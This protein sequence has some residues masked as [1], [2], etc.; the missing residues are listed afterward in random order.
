MAVPV[1]EQRKLFQRSGDRCAFPRCGKALTAQQTD[2]EP[3][4]A[5]GEIAHIVG[6]SPNGPRGTSPLRS[7]QRNRYENLILLCNY[8]HQLIDSHP[9]SWS[10]AQLE[11][12]KRTH[13]EWVRHRLG[14]IDPVTGSA[15]QSTQGG[16]DFIEWFITEADRWPIVD[17][18]ADRALLGIH[19]ALP[20]PSNPHESLSVQLPEYVQRD[21]DTELR[22]AVGGA[23]RRSGFIV[24]VGPSASGKTRSAYE[25]VHAQ[26]ADWRMIIPPTA[27]DLDALLR[28]GTP[29]D[30]SVIWLDEL[31][32]YLD[33]GALSLRTFHKILAEH[34]GPLLVIGT[35]WP[36][37]FDRICEPPIKD[38]SRDSSA[39]A[40]SIL[41]LATRFDI[42][43]AFTESEYQRATKISERD[44]R[45]RQALEHATDAAIPSGLACAPELIHRW[46]QPSDPVGAAVI[47]AAV[48]ARLC[49]HPSVI[50]PGLLQLLAAEYLT[51]AQRATATADW[52][53]KALQ[54]AMRPIRG[55]V[56]ALTPAARRIGELDGYQPSDILTHR[57]AQSYAM[58]RQ[59][60][61]KP[62][63]VLVAHADK[64]ASQVIAVFASYCGY[65]DTA[66]AAWVRLAEAGDTSAMVALGLARLDD[67]DDE[68]AAP[69]FRRAADAG[70]TEAMGLL[71]VALEQLGR[72]DEARAWIRRGAEAGVPVA[73]V[74]LGRI[75]EDDGDYE[76]ARHWYEA[77]TAAG[78]DGTGRL[79]L[80]CMLRDQGD[81]ETACEY[82]HEAAEAGR[83]FAGPDLH[84]TAMP[85]GVTDTALG[86]YRESVTNTYASAAFCLGEIYRSQERFDEAKTWFHRAANLGRVDG[87]TALG[88]LVWNEGE[89]E[90]ALTWLRPA[91]EAGEPEAMFYVAMALDE[92]EET[93]EAGTWFRK[94][95]LAGHPMAM[96]RYAI[97]LRE[98]GEDGQALEW[99]A[100]AR[101]A[102]DPLVDLCFA[103]ANEESS[104]PPLRV[105]P[106]DPGDLS[107]AISWT[108]MAHTCE[109]VTDWGWDSEHADPLRFIAWCSGVV[110]EEC[111]WHAAGRS[112]EGRTPLLVQILPHG[113]AFYA[114]PATGTDVELGRRI[115]SGV[116]ELLAMAEHEDE[117]G[118]LATISPEYRAWLES[119][120]YDVAE[121]WFK[122]R[123]MDLVLNR[124]A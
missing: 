97:Y 93:G 76:G 114:R 8:H 53:D 54:W 17:S 91:A 122:T 25:A 99:L 38:H 60:P 47:T 37:N 111:P 19:P 41:R 98:Q 29:L 103:A 7:D 124:L 113:P 36:D 39:D 109:C 102:G 30:H 22:E 1:A 70:D 46:E 48:E 50:P 9:T 73:M 43:S 32:G 42:A 10:V 119:E 12:M 28:S 61:S 57:A 115:T 88:A 86:R 63:D 27:S 66:E 87:K 18:S 96:G 94:A 56:A 35:I 117:A 104:P 44:P 72:S 77:A 13:E 116:Q 59:S 64:D 71:A 82:L 55:D 23:A 21:V 121:E 58:R 16:G 89:H 118:I 4:A 26:L 78:D 74:G 69:W 105:I 67:G 101:E 106:L 90:L 112:H 11:E 3:V 84:H 33:S 51:S 79:F 40:A 107:D 15:D 81:L 92:L 34:T 14:S 45:I 75:L 24:L 95:A 85:V 108:P 62:W 5:L 6:D 20:L 49:G 68:G 80:G 123:L 110:T 52:F 65:H 2:S 31:A 100:K 120:A 83:A